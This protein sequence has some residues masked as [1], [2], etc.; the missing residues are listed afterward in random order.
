[1]VRWVRACCLVASCGLLGCGLLG[2]G[3][4]GCD[5]AAEHKKSFETQIE[6]KIDAEV[7][8]LVGESSA[9]E[10]ARLSKKV[11]G[12]VSSDTTVRPIYRDVGDA[13]E[14]DSEIE[15]MPK[16]EV[17]NGVTVGFERMRKLSASEKVDEDAY[18]VLWRHDDKIVGFVYRKKSRIDFDALV[19]ETPKLMKLFSG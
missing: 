7:N 13:D 14:V 11:S 15:D 5:Q 18:L 4:L 3:L 1:M 2:C 12:A 17:I 6:R 9:K 10:I 19:A 16:K 8:A